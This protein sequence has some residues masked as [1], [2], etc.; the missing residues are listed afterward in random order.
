MQKEKID[1]D[2]VIISRFDFLKELNV[3]IDLNNIDNKKIYVS[4]I[5]KPRALFFDGIVLSSVE[6]Y[7]KIFN[8]YDNLDNLINNKT[9]DTLISNYN[10]KLVLVSEGL[11]FANYLYYFKDIQTLKYVNF[12]N[13]I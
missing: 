1:Y 9:L 5:H 11:M 2:F 7:F 4:N 12:P 10:D 13:F 8:I 6:N 3:N